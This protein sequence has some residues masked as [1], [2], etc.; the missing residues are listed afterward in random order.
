MI[1]IN[2]I[3]DNKFLG[4]DKIV[5]ETPIP[6]LMKEKQWAMEEIMQMII[7]MKMTSIFNHFA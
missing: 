1:N 4:M 2:L 3:L 5:M 7:K 6:I